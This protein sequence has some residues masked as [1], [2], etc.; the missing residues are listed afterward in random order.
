M[1]HMQYSDI[2]THWIA[3]CALNYNVTYF[4]SFVVEYVSNKI[5]TF[6]NGSTINRNIFI[7][8]AHDSVLCRYFCIGYIDFMFKGKSLT[9][10]T[11][12]FLPKN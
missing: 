8:Q 7:I 4:D 2:G 6:I 9:D 11:N 1:E 3:L 12:F 10:F 5:K